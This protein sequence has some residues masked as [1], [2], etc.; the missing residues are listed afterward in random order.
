MTPR[1]WREKEG[2][3]QLA[4]AEMLGLSDGYISLLEKGER[5]PSW[6]VIQKYK[7]VSNGVVT[8]DSFQ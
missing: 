7:Q 2:L 1:E 3:S 5:K 4:A 6:S 8:A